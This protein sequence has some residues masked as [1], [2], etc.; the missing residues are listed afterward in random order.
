MEQKKPKYKVLIVDDDRDLLEVLSDIFTG[1]GYKVVTA[2]DGQDA[3]FK[4]NNEIFD[5]ILSD[6]RMPKKDGIKFVQFIQATEA[7]KMLKSGQSFRPTPIIMISASVEDYRVELEVLGNIEVLNKPFTP[8]EVME[9][10]NQLL[11]KKAAPPSQTNGNLMTFKA[12]EYVIKEGDSS[13]DI[14]FVKEGTLNVIK[15]ATNGKEVMI[16]VI[17]AGEVLG[18]MGVLMR[19][20]RTAS[21]IAKTDSVLISIPKEKI[22]AHISSQPKWFKILFDAIATRLEETTISLV[23]ERSRK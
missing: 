4:F 11:E 5:I 18:E 17:N 14:F 19:R 23:E 2:T 6:I 16:S 12:G 20:N 9:K 10:V 1:A 3:T 21:V 22:E 13:G 8:R 15:K 7:Q